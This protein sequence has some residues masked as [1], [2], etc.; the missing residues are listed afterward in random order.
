MKVSDMTQR[1]FCTFN[2]KIHLGEYEL[3]L[4]NPVIWRFQIWHKDV[5]VPLMAK[6]TL[7][8]MSF[9]FVTQWYE[10]FGY[11]TKTFPWLWWQKWFWELQ[12]SSPY[13]CNKTLTDMRRLDGELSVWLLW[14]W[15]LATQMRAH[16]KQ[17]HFLDYIGTGKFE[18][19]VAT[20]KKKRQKKKNLERNPEMEEE[21]NLF[22]WYFGEILEKPFK[23]W[24]YEFQKAEIAF[25]KSK[26]SQIS[27]NL[28][29]RNLNLQSCSNDFEKMTPQRIKSYCH[30]ILSWR[31]SPIRHQHWVLAW[32]WPNASK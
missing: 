9:Y 17:R 15:F 29:P 13:S 4:C 20:K 27:E 11:D 26:F 25:C 31:V 22:L 1:R 6:F 21:K 3:L 24:M 5:S 8:N 10:G 2:G 28:S 19:R 12:G 7:E 32:V 23:I 14:L 30:M 18:D 16:K